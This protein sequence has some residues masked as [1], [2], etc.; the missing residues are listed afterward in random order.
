MII[1]QLQRL[2]ACVLSAVLFLQ[3]APFVFAAETSA[4]IPATVAAQVYVPVFVPQAFLSDSELKQALSLYVEDVHTKYPEKYFQIISFDEE[5]TAYDIFIFLEKWFFQGGKQNGKNIKLDGAVF[6]GDIPLPNIETEHEFF[7]PSFA[8][9]I[10]FIEPKYVFLDTQNFKKTSKQYIPET[11]YGHIPLTEKTELL[12]YLNRVHTLYEGGSEDFS[13]VSYFDFLKPKSAA[14]SKR[15]LLYQL[16]QKYAED[17]EYGRFS[18]N[19]YKNLQQEVAEINETQIILEESQLEKFLS[20]Q[21]SLWDIPTFKEIEREGMSHMPDILSAPLIRELLP[22]YVEV[23]EG[24]FKQKFESVL[25]TGSYSPSDIIFVEKFIT[26]KDNEGQK[27]LRGVNEKMKKK[28][29]RFVENSW[30]VPVRIAKEEQF[31]DNYDNNYR[32]VPLYILGSKV[33]DLETVEQ[34]SMKKGSPRTDEEPLSQQV[35]RNRVFD[36]H[37]SPRAGDA[38]CNNYS[39]NNLGACRSAQATSP[40]LSETGTAFAAGTDVPSFQSCQNFHVSSTH[41]VVSYKNL[42]S[43][44]LHDE[45]RRKTLERHIEADLAVALPIDQNPF[46]QFQS[47]T[48][49]LKKILF[50]NVFDQKDFQKFLIDEENQISSAAD[51]SYEKQQIRKS[52][53][54]K[55]LDQ[56]TIELQSFDDNGTRNNDVLL[57]EQQQLLEEFSFLHLSYLPAQFYNTLFSQEDIWKI[58]EMLTWK[59]FSIEEKVHYT[60]LTRWNNRK[61]EIMYL[62]SHTQDNSIFFQSEFSPSD[63]YAE[64]WQT[65]NNLEKKEYFIIPG[66]TIQIPFT[67]KNVKE[68]QTASVFISPRS[69]QFA[70]FTS[71]KIILD[72]GSGSINIQAKNR[73]GSIFVKITDESD[74]NQP[75]L[76]HIQVGTKMSQSALGESLFSYI[77]SPERIKTPNSYLLNSVASLHK[78]TFPEDPLA[79]IGPDGMA[80]FSQP[81]LQMYVDEHWKMNLTS[82]GKKKADWNMKVTEMHLESQTSGVRIIP[83]KEGFI[84]EFP[85]NKTFR[86]SKD[87]FE[88][89]ETIQTRIFVEDGKVLITFS[90]ASQS[91]TWQL[92]TY[93]DGFIEQES[94]QVVGKNMFALSPENIDFDRF[95]GWQ[96]QDQSL[97]QLHSGVSFGKALA[98]EISEFD[99]LYGDPLFQ[100]SIQGEKDIAKNQGEKIAKFSQN[101]KEFVFLDMN[102]NGHTDI[103]TVL[104]SGDMILLSGDGAQFS[105]D[106]KIAKISSSAKNIRSVQGFQESP[107]DIIYID[108]K[109]LYYL[110]NT[111]AFQK[112][113]LFF[114]HTSNIEQFE[115]IDINNDDNQDIV[116][117]DETNTLLFLQMTQNGFVVSHTQSFPFALSNF[118]LEAV[119]QKILFP[120]ESFVL[121]QVSGAWEILPINNDFSAFSAENTLYEN[122]DFDRGRVVIS[123]LMEEVRDIQGVESELLDLNTLI[124][125]REELQAVLDVIAP[126]KNT[127]ALMLQ[128]QT[129]IE[130]Q[131]LVDI[132]NQITPLENLVGALDILV[133]NGGLPDVSRP[134]SQFLELSALQDPLNT[135]DALSELIFQNDPMAQKIEQVF[136]SLTYTESAST[137][138]TIED[139]LKNI[140]INTLLESANM[141]EISGIVGA[142]QNGP[143]MFSIESGMNIL[144]QSNVQNIAGFSQIQNISGVISNFTSLKNIDFPNL[145]GNIS[146]VSWLK[147]EKLQ[148]V[149]EKVKKIKNIVGKFKQI[150]NT[151]AN[152]TSRIQAIFSPVNRSIGVPGP[153]VKLKQS[154]EKI[155]GVLSSLSGDRSGTRAGKEQGT[156]LAGI[157]TA[158]CLTATSH[159]VWIPALPVPCAGPLCY[160]KKG[161]SLPPLPGMSKCLST[162][163]PYDFRKYTALSTTGESVQAFAIGKADNLKASPSFPALPITPEAI[164]NS[165]NGGVFQFPTDFIKSPQSFSDAFGQGLKNPLDGAENI[166]DGKINDITAKYSGV[167]DQ[168]K[169]LQSQ[170]S[171]GSFNPTSLVSSKLEGIKSKLNVFKNPFSFSEKTA[172]FPT[173]SLSGLSSLRQKFPKLPSLG[174]AMKQASSFTKNKGISMMNVSALSKKMPGNILKNAQKMQFKNID[175]SGLQKS[176]F[177][178]PTLKIPQIPKQSFQFIPS[179]FAA[180]QGELKARPQKVSSQTVQKTAPVKTLSRKVPTNLFQKKSTFPFFE[181]L[182]SPWWNAQV[183]EFS[184][185]LTL[186]TIHLS[187]PDFQPLLQN[188]PDE[189][190][191]PFFI[192]DQLASASLFHISQDKIVQTT[193]WMSPVS[194]QL[195]QAQIEAWKEKE[196]TN[197]QN[198]I[199]TSA[200]CETAECLEPISQKKKEWSDYIDYINQLQSFLTELEQ[201]Y[202]DIAQYHQDIQK[203][204]LRATEYTTQYVASYSKWLEKSRPALQSYKELPGK[205][206]TMKKSWLEIDAVYK[207]Y[208]KSCDTGR[209]DVYS[210]NDALFQIFGEKPQAPQIIKAPNLQDFSLQ[211]ESSRSIEF[212]LP[213][214]VIVPK[215]FQI[216]SPGRNY[217]FTQLSHIPASPKKQNIPIILDIPQVP[218]FP[219]FTAPDFPTI[220]L[221]PILA[222][223][224]SSVKQMKPVITKQLDLYCRVITGKMGSEYPE[225]ELSKI[226]EA[227]TNRPN[228]LIPTD[229]SEGFAPTIRASLLDG[230]HVNTVIN[231]QPLDYV[232]K[233]E[234]DSGIIISE[235]MPAQGVYLFDEATGEVYNILQDKKRGSKISGL[236]FFDDDTDGDLDI[237]YVYKNALYKKKNTKIQLSKMTGGIMT[238]QLL[239]TAPDFLS[240]QHSLFIDND[241]LLFGKD[242][243]QHRI[244]FDTGVSY[245]AR[246]RLKLPE[247]LSCYFCSVWVSPSQIVAVNEVASERFFFIND[248]DKKYTKESMTESTFYKKLLPQKAYSLS[249]SSFIAKDWKNIWW[250]INND[251]IPDEHTETIQL[252]P[253]AEVGTYKIS[254]I[255]ED[256]TGQVHHLEIFLQ[257]ESPRIII[258]SV[259]SKGA[260]GHIEPRE[261]DIHISFLEK[262]SRGEILYDV[263]ENIVTDTFGDFTFSFSQKNTGTI[264]YDNNKRKIARIEAGK[265]FE[266]LDDSINVV[267]AAETPSTPLSL[268]FDRAGVTQARIALFAPQSG[269]TLIEKPED[270]QQKGAFIHIHQSNITSQEI[271]PIEAQENTGMILSWGNEKQAVISSLG[272]IQLLNA[273]DVTLKFNDADWSVTAYNSQNEKIFTVFFSFGKRQYQALQYFPS[274]SAEE[275]V[276]SDLPVDH[277]YAKYLLELKEKEIFQGYPDGTIRPD[278]TI[279]RSEF[280]K[281]LL[282]ADTC[283][284]CSSPDFVYETSNTPFS[285]IETADWFFACVS[286]SKEKK[287]V[288]GYGDGTFGPHNPISRKEA[289]TILLRHLDKN[290]ETMPEGYFGDV[291]SDD[292]AKDY[293]YTGYNMGLFPDFLG[294]ISPNEHITRGEFAFMISSISQ[295][296]QCRTQQRFQEDPDN[297]ENI[298]SSSSVS[299]DSQSFPLNN[300]SSQP[301]SSESDNASSLNTNN[302][303]SQKIVLS[304]G[305]TFQS[306]GEGTEIFTASNGDSLIILSDGQKVI[307]SA[308]ADP[309][310]LPETTKISDICMDFPNRQCPQTYKNAASSLFIVPYSQNNMTDNTQSNILTETVTE[311]LSDQDSASNTP[312]DTNNTP[313]DRH[314]T[315]DESSVNNDSVSVAESGIENTSGDL[316]E[317]HDDTV[318]VEETSIETNDEI[319]RI[320]TSAPLVK[321]T[322]DINI[323][324]KQSFQKLEINHQYFFQIR[325]NNDQIFSES[326]QFSLVE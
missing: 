22:E 197:I 113:K 114:Q 3:S 213:R 209:A 44:S 275:N 110:E 151:V 320:E 315:A 293:L 178:L 60:L 59:D 14:E 303:P 224:L 235:P 318:F 97:L 206:E 15:F 187:L 287:L 95:S 41:A 109:Q 159:P 79:F 125:K 100:L 20:E 211:I 266:I 286:I 130:G 142:I 31:I 322:N 262:M 27:F 4:V 179:V 132:Q 87:L 81:S 47:E 307:R 122:E 46:I 115:F 134:L 247:N 223:S 112:P 203:V 156:P 26:E 254:V 98:K 148:N 147:S 39:Y 67:F 83:D 104:A 40:V 28:L 61:S 123:Q 71:K 150:K 280:V 36:I 234:G 69:K 19:F 267:V 270:I 317:I 245:T 9:F 298:R 222:P 182:L 8:P 300:S 273:Q 7:A 92:T 5:K 55:R 219:D 88:T 190:E 212:L 249:L 63:I 116:I 299:P 102:G 18:Q 279:T 292:W 216:I 136:T 93:F 290:I 283:K 321:N 220:P 272:G 228:T 225:A 229:F 140:G 255:A 186:P 281:V 184:K 57:R 208:M 166:V 259:N 66:E 158:K 226:A 239:P 241:Y 284:D 149:V 153:H 34:C 16:R 250:D 90:Q 285:D 10:D 78:S 263:P 288:T 312:N 214:L 326:V 215:A 183:S 309:V 141:L 237:F 143:D 257:I 12:S 172:V 173:S 277:T 276:F 210:Q 261:K 302:T 310:F 240:S 152:I 258:D 243:R 301:V 169:N 323:Q 233:A 278:N 194:L 167:F 192:F 199:N 265:I 65:E 274:V 260:R 191:N 84:M 139:R 29:V 25:S 127:G 13:D 45:P 297:I 291:S 282:T 128:A 75:I 311:N 119:G 207:D 129:S 145:G 82:F 308:D 52:A 94:F 99:V 324:W 2:S 251:N 74:N 42:S 21:Q 268:L 180:E 164:A 205:I 50:S 48:G 17:I 304:S 231:L 269:V 54:T 230:Q 35:I 30:Q 162:P 200:Q 246:K 176:K 105:L 161:A 124:E 73:D 72:Q 58:Q 38:G 121:S 64:E 101:I 314:N 135:D 198:F 70:S 68:G 138:N 154:T 168:A 244:V 80:Y 242:E 264:L 188:V 89:D 294:Y 232:G 160:A 202:E 118:T 236:Q 91:V 126:L 171:A 174:G 23:S 146:P 120:Q 217:D 85:Q 204:S 56:I 51:A 103:I 6:F 218:N 238:K 165:L 155:T 271:F 221:A 32:T 316:P 37:A 256:T 131:A 157:R 76:L 133:E 43:V 295:N 313:N 96:G 33:S 319:E 1:K 289:V 296:F 253:F 53:I 181:S 77:V 248:T 117:R 163:A 227:L 170:L 111:G 185:M 325:G 62:K 306:L 196:L 144:S 189:K 86:I 252:D 108:E 175:L 137:Q 49:G 11:W 305:L 193:P 106:G 107:Q 201:H 24:F 195:A 177:S